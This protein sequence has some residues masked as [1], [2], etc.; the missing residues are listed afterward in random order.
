MI[1][2]TWIVHNRQIHGD[3]KP[4]SD[5]LVLGGREES[6]EWLLMGKGFILELWNV[7]KLWQWLH[8]SENILNIE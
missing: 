7:L 8:R 1:S 4:V 2:F 5:Y 6:E 3:R